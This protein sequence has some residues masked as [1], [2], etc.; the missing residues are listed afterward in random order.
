MMVSRV[1]LLLLVTGLFAGMWSADSPDGRT[2]AQQQLA[3][4]ASSPRA[5]GRAD[6]SANSRINSVSLPGRWDERAIPRPRGIAP[7]TYLVVDQAGITQRVT[8]TAR[9]GESANHATVEQYTVR[10]GDARWH[11]IRLE[12]RTPDGPAHPATAAV[13]R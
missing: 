7:G 6:T 3:R 5:L 11:F 1:S 8:I 10:S 9:D 13:P 4:R 12:E 2:V